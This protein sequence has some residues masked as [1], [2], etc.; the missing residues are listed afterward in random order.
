LS[1][2]ISKPSKVFARP[3]GSGEGEDSSSVLAYSLEGTPVDEGGAS[4]LRAVFDTSSGENSV[5]ELAFLGE[6]EGDLGDLGEEG[7]LAFWTRLLP[8]FFGRVSL[9]ECTLGECSCSLKENSSSRCWDSLG[10]T[11]R[12]RLGPKEQQ[13][14]RTTSGKTQLCWIPIS[15][16]NQNTK[17][18]TTKREDTQEVG[19]CHKKE[20][21]NRNRRSSSV[22]SHLPNKPPIILPF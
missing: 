19:D 21:V 8:T 5:G 11:T 10:S 22:E 15:R 3:E 13:G 16:T 18:T 7:D 2:R 4:C 12:E 14:R 20:E 6:V 17:N 9:K 1:S